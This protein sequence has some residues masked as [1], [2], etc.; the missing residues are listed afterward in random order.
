MKK[1]VLLGL[2]LALVVFVGQA[3]A[4]PPEK[5]S[6]EVVAGHSSGNHRLDCTVIRPWKDSAG[7]ADIL[8]P[9]IVWA[10]GWGWNDVAGEDSTEGDGENQQASEVA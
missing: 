4:A 6:E 8:Y 7:P 9:V 2:F 10:N 3:Y 5:Y 1:I